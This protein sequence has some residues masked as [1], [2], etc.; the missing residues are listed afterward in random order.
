[1]AMGLRGE[2]GTHKSREKQRD[3]RTSSSHIYGKEIYRETHKES[4][5][6]T[7]TQ[8]KTERHTHPT[9]RTHRGR[10]K[11]GASPPEKLDPLDPRVMQLALK[12]KANESSRI[13][14]SKNAPGRKHGLVPSPKTP[15]ILYTLSPRLSPDQPC[16]LVSPEMK[17]EGEA[18]GPTESGAT[19]TGWLRN[20]DGS[21]P[22]AGT[23]EDPDAF[24][25]INKGA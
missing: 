13:S 18:Q 8:T 7:D 12:P 20:H 17:K 16:T 24:C 21:D 4:R 9:R 22:H 6:Q 3:R 14:E 23:W 19:F 25:R 10:G 5:A 15:S 11:G 2:A 1:M